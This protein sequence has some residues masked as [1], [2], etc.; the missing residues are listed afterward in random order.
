MNIIGGGAVA[1]KVSPPPP[2]SRI[3]IVHPLLETLEN[4]IRRTRLQ[5]KFSVTVTFSHAAR[6]FLGGDSVSQLAL[7]IQSSIK[8]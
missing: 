8:R 2:T 6:A 5:I 3:M 4:R 1:A 7:K